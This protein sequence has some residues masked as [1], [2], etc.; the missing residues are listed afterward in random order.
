MLDVTKAA[1]LF[2]KG[3]ILVEGITEALLVPVLARRAGFNLEH[4][5]VS[6]VPVCGVDFA[7]I[8]RLFG[9]Q[10]IRIPLAVV[11]DGDAVTERAESDEVGSWE[12]R[13]PKMD[14]GKPA[15]CA[16]VQGLLDAYGGHEFVGIF[17]SDVTLEYSLAAAGAQNPGLMCKVWEEQYEAAPRTLNSKK[18]KECVG[19]HE[20]EVLAVWRGICLANATCSKAEFAQAIAAHLEK[21][22]KYGNYIVPLTD[23]V[24]PP[25]LQK[26]FSHV[27]APAQ[28][29][30]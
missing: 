3:V 17:H 16:R 19:N 4:N 30:H 20:S 27:T 9:D 18:L 14:G 11:T 1:L 10:G 7:T 5:G 25:Y 22:D 21:K 15:I 8:S 12:S 23:F 29:A 24:I 28:A 6:V 13:L 2:A 26:A